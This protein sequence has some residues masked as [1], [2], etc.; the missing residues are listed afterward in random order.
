MSSLSF[1]VLALPWLSLPWL[2]SPSPLL[3][4]L[5]PVPL[6]VGVIL[7]FLF[8]DVVFVQAFSMTP[9]YYH[10]CMCGVCARMLACQKFVLARVINH[11]TGCT[12]SKVSW[13][14]DVP[15][16]LHCDI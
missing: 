11:E 14:P 7:D 2:A 10:S 1:V 3:G 8:L 4:V 6:G 5:R 12:R 13:G 9:S 15:K 16:I